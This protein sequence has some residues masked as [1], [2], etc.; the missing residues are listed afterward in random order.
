MQRFYTCLPPALPFALFLPLHFSVL[1]PLTFSEVYK[2]DS[3]INHLLLEDTSAHCTYVHE[4]HNMTQVEEAW[5]N[6][7]VY[8]NEEAANNFTPI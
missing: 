1:N 5:Q 3:D 8:A 4:L 2:E 6:K 7:L